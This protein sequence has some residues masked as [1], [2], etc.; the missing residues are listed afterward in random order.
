MSIDEAQ[1]QKGLE[2]FDKVY[3]PGSSEMTRPYRDSSFNQEIV[4]NQFANLWASDILSMREKRL[5]V[6]GATAM[7]GRPDLVEIQMNGALINGEL[8]DEELDFIP[9]FMLFYAGAGNT[10]ALF[11]GIEAAKARRKERSAAAG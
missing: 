11:R 2:V 8:T 3:G 4:G 9:L 5:M 7:L 1:W 6:L 10:T